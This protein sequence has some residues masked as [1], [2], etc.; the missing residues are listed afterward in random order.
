[1]KKWAHVSN[2]PATTRKAARR[3]PVHEMS[4]SNEERIRTPPT[5]RGLRAVLLTVGRHWS[6]V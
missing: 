6:D 1:M 5:R 4:L 3:R 2:A